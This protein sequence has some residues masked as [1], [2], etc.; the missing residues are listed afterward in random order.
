[1]IRSEVTPARGA[2]SGQPALPP[3]GFLGQSITFVRGVGPRRAAPLRR[4]GIETVRDAL[5]HFPRAYED[6]RSLRPI[7][8]LRIG[9][10]ESFAARVEGGGP[11]VSRRRGARRYQVVF[12]DQTGSI[13]AVWFNFR[14]P[15]MEKTYR[16][17][18]SFI[19]NGEVRWDG[20]RLVIY[21]PETEPVDDAANDAASPNF[22]R[23]VPLYPLTE[24]LTQRSLRGIVHRVLPAAAPLLGDDLPEALRRR[25]HLPSLPETL[26]NLH[27]P[28]ADA[29]LEALNDGRSPWHKRLVFEEF[30]FHQLWVLERRRARQVRRRPH[31]LHDAPAL[32]ERFT[33]GLPYHL[34]QDQW[35]AFQEIRGDMLSP[36]PMYR[37]LQGDVGSG[38]TV[39]AAMASLLAQG[40]GLQTAVMAPTEILARQHFET[41]DRLFTG[42][43]V[44][45][46]LLVS[47]QG[48]AQRRETLEAIA[49]G[50]AQVVVGTHALFQD[51]VR[52]RNLGLVI[53]DEQHRF[54]VLQR[55]ALQEKGNDP[56]TLVV[57]A[58]PIPRT[59]AMTFYG[60]MEVSSI[61][62][63]PPG[64][65]PVATRVLD[66]GQR[67]LLHDLLRRELEQGHR[68][69]VVYPLVEEGGASDLR[70]AMTMAG[71][72]RES[73]LGVHG[74][75]LV[76]GRLKAAEKEAVM[77]GFASGSIKILVATTVVEVGVDVPEATVMVVEHADRFGL[78]QLHQLRGRVGRGSRE[79]TCILLSSPGI[80]P[81]PLRRLEILASTHDGFL[82]AEED[83][84]SRGP[85]EFTGARQSGSPDVFLH[86]LMR[87]HRA[88]E[89][90]RA[91]ASAVLSDLP[92]PES[93]R[94]LH[95]ART[96]WEERARFLAGG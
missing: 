94:L 92:Q 32:L 30:F 85:G 39:V 3:D 13:A 1:M 40:S 71:R 55:T 38:K 62:H 5:F 10:R 18:L 7:A 96:R 23:I 58:T 61:R 67:D 31:P 22:R 82:L 88:L 63:L 25:Y 74:V 83:L 73:S 79:S 46:V 45:Q 47:G 76:H 95:L 34:T 8:R 91:E 20:T 12:R 11:V 29:D 86:N 81:E 66:D 78:S 41:F 19:L 48:H 33:S 21:H 54:G 68:A 6:R 75:G 64:R 4:L 44:N 17:G 53:I 56:D 15:V 87:F 77:A 37:L 51:R 84:K 16:P 69:F 50:E 43:G 28:G 2:R 9:S 89:Y 72:L 24:S 36:S 42:L 27:F 93:V 70:A 49:R 90:A 60:D 14:E 35:Q 26:T 52:Y 59:L 65:R 80:G 57:S